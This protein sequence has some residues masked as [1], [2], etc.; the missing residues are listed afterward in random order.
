M[1]YK[2]ACVDLRPGLIKKTN[3]NDGIKRNSYSKKIVSILLEVTKKKTIIMKRFKKKKIF[4]IFWKNF[5]I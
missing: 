5:I 1:K 3:K 2:D 4:Y